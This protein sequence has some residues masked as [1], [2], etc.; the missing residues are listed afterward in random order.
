MLT[1]I[2]VLTQ[3]PVDET[4]DLDEGYRNHRIVDERE[5]RT[6]SEARQW[7]LSTAALYPTAYIT[8]IHE[9]VDRDWVVIHDGSVNIP[10]EEENT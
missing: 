10:E 3:L 6:E 9:T 8:L 5:F 1:R 7:A 2:L 4:E